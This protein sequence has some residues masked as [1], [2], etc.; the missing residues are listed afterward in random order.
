MSAKDNNTNTNIY[1]SYIDALLYPEQNPFIEDMKRFEEL[2]MMYSCAIKE[3]QTK[4]DV[5]NTD[6]SVRY[7]RNPI[8]F[9]QSRIKKPVSI[10]TK[11]SSRGCQVSVENIV[12]N[13]NDV[14]GLRV[15]C[16]FIDDI[17]A[18]AEKL[19]SQNDITLI[20][21]KD[22]ISHPKPNGYRRLHLIIEVPVF[23]ADHTRNMR[24]EGSDPYHRD[25][26]LGKS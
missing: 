17:Y 7:N 21:A 1:R 4:L 22:Y 18:V 24:V 5:L 8:E 14:A 6:F 20:E 23:F 2:M 26:L 11:L 9:I 3:V 13:L 15:I 25:G 16:S 19:I 10:A 12:Y